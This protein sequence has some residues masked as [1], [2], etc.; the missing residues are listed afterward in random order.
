MMMVQ[1]G[2][3]FAQTVDDAVVSIRDR[4]GPGRLTIYPAHTQPCRSRGLTWFEF[5]IHITEE[6]NGV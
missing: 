6:R 4:Y 2:R 5:F 1:P 3:I